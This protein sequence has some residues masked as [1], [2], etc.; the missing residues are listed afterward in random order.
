MALISR[1][2]SG[3]HSGVRDRLEVEIPG[4]EDPELVQNDPVEVERPTEEEVSVGDGV[5]PPYVEPEDLHVV[6]PAVEVE[7]LGDVSVVE[8]RSN[9]MWAITIRTMSHMSLDPNDDPVSVCLLYTSPSP[10]D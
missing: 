9:G 3:S 2:S 5:M 10:R 1:S 6:R 8:E 4:V 7:R